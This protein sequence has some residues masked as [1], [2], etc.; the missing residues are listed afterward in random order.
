[1]KTTKRTSK[2][3]LLLEQALQEWRDSCP[4]AGWEHHTTA[5]LVSLAMTPGMQQ[6]LELASEAINVRELESYQRSLNDVRP[7]K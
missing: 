3:I 7:S 6:L 1:M 4:G 2:S 5:A